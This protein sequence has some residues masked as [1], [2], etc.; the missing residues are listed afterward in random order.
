MGY[1]GFIIL[2]RG[3]TKRKVKFL[4]HQI[5]ASL[6]TYLI[7]EAAEL[8][9]IQAEEFYSRLDYIKANGKSSVSKSIEL[10]KSDYYEY[11]HLD[12][13]ASIFD[14]QEKERMGLHHFSYRI[15]TLSQSELDNYIE[16]VDHISVQLRAQLAVEAWLLANQFRQKYKLGK[17]R[18]DYLNWDRLDYLKSL[19]ISLQKEPLREIS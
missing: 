17:R 18:F 8:R 5:A 6:E 9:Y 14:L 12:L 13:L 3:K 10:P 7:N 1:E 16:E 4:A 15:L 11:L 19:A 2:S